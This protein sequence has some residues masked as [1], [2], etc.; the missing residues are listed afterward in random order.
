ME[1]SD[2]KQPATS[3]SPETRAPALPSVATAG[4]STANLRNQ[5]LDASAAGDRS[6]PLHTLRNE[7]R[8][9]TRDL[10]IARS[11]EH[12]SEL[13]SL[14]YLVCRLLLEKKKKKITK[15]DTCPVQHPH[16]FEYHH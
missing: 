3:T 4:Q 15:T 8:V 1:R 11:E 7:I 2:E 10:L 5:N 9:W 16:I 14:A 13:Q 6:A 12:T